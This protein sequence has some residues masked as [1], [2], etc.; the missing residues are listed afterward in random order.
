M[1]EVKNKNIERYPTASITKTEFWGMPLGEELWGDNFVS[2]TS[3]DNSK[4]TVVMSKNISFNPARANVGS[5]GINMS[6]NSVAVSGAYP[7]FRVKDKMS[8]LF[9]P[10]YVYLEIKYN[11]EVQQDIAARAYGT[12]RQSLNAEEFLKLQIRNISEQEQNKI[13]SDAK[14]KFERYNE[15][16]NELFNFKMY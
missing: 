12:I 14:D 7:V 5:F 8:K 4:Y 1:E 2:V 11:P 6:K 15:L 3:E 16:K 9:L 10:E 13:V